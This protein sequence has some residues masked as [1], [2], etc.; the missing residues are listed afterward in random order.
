MT[1]RYVVAALLYLLA[2]TRVAEPPPLTVCEVLANLSA[3]R[4]KW[5]SVRGQLISNEHMVALFGRGCA[6]LVTD[7][8]QWQGPAAIALTY[9]GTGELQRFLNPDRPHGPIAEADPVA[10]PGG[11]GAPGEV[12]ITASGRLNTNLHFV[13]VRLNDGTV[14]P[15][16]FGPLNSFP[17]EL[18]YD[19][20]TDPVRTVPAA[21]G[22]KP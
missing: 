13:L 14:R 3:Y 4:G 11:T 20:L 1:V 18:V 17:A 22:G 10:P 21:G 9:P 2:Q 12:D 16:G 8:F 19:R 15:A 5:I 7:G 6:P